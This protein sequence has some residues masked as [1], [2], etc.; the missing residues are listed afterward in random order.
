MN[1]YIF[2]GS[3]EGLLCCAASA[4]KTKK[5][6]DRVV[7]IHENFQPI[8]FEEEHSIVTDNDM[9]ERAREYLGKNNNVLFRAYL[10]DTD[11]K[12]L[13]IVKCMIG[14]YANLLFLD[15]LEMEEVKNVHKASKRVG[16]EAMRMIEFVRFRELTDGILFSEI[17]PK[18]NILSWMAGHFKRRLP[19]E[20]WMI[21]DSMRSLLLSHIEGKTEY[22]SEVSQEEV[23]VLSDREEEFQE[24]WQVFFDSISI[25]E[26]ENYN[27]QRQHVPLYYRGLM[28]EFS[29]K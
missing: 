19:N 16:T 21:F 18:A 5:I 23:P 10:M 26:R 8:L 1:T 7:S 20:N 27:L 25:K 11:P 28:T 15:R 29:K 12:N 24:L 6:P 9:A 14:L 17:R 4:Y 13:D 3:Y 2:D 22:H